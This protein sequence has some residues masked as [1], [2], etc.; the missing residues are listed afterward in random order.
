[1]QLDMTAYETM[2]VLR[3]A[4]GGGNEAKEDMK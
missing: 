2:D 3:N 4:L 1:M